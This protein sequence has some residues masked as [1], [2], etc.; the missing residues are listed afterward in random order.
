MKKIFREFK[1]FAM[2]GNMIDMAVGIIIGGGFGKLV[3]SL[4]NDILMPPIGVL[5]GNVNYT[6]LKIT[7]KRAYMNADGVDMPAV[8]INYG[9]FTQTLIDFIIVAFCIFMVVKGINKL[10]SLSKEKTESEVEPTKEEQL[11]TE[12]RDI[13][14][15]KTTQL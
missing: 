12:I 15:N 7:L 9:N 10:R 13:L 3:S 6:D 5:L 14:K 1:D 11:L 8:T 4:V 2:R